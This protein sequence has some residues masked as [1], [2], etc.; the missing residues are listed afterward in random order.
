MIEYTEDTQVFYDNTSQIVNAD[1]PT[2]KV[3]SVILEGAK[4]YE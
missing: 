3:F 4:M 1:N 2:W